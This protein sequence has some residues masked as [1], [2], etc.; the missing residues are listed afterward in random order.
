MP[1]CVTVANAT[2]HTQ[3]TGARVTTGRHIN[4]AKT[5]NQNKTKT[6][7]IH[8]RPVSHHASKR[9]PLE[10]GMHGAVHAAAQ[11]TI[12]TIVVIF[13]SIIRTAI[14]AINIKH[15]VTRSLEPGFPHVFVLL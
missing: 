3:H 7:A 5:S 6:K 1:A 10:T 12:I 14:S 11:P 13:G 9:Q 15:V 4:G 2:V 8:N